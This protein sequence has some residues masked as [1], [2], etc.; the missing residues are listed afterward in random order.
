M[1]V[2]HLS[3]DYP[4]PLAPAKTRAVS[5]L[6]ALVSEIEH[7]VYALNRVGWR[8][9]IHALSFDDACGAGH[10]AVAYGA[11]PKGLLHAVF[12]DRLADWILE[13]LARD[14]FR[15]DLVHAHKLSVEGLAGARVAHA[16]GTP[17]ALS[18]QGNSDTK[19]VGAKRDL[20][21]RYA[22]IW[23]DAAVAFPF[24]PWAARALETM[25]G[26]RDG[27]TLTLPCPGPADGRLPP[28]IVGPIIRTAFHLG[29]ARGKNADGLIRAVGAAAARVPELRLEIA[30]GGDPA[31]FAALSRV[32]ARAA[33]GR[34]RFLGPVPH[35]RVQALFNAS[36]A[37]A[38]V[39]HRESFG[40]VF[41]EALSAGAP[42]LTPRG[43]AIDGYFEEG[44]VVLAADPRDGAE[45][46]DG[47][48]RLALEEAAFKARLAALSESGG[49]DFLTSRAI[50]RQYRSGIA[51]AVSCAGAATG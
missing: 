2:L 43:R 26:R 48:V 38:L 32:A 50:A 46:R 21:D 44:G 35:D 41:A 47:L 10:R 24:A 28:R 31:Q 15:P 18:I 3:A 16:L 49:L 30:G 33:P 42:C 19:I 25:L 45:I 39:S 23:R 8:A 14:G 4:D 7:R 29:G 11:P 13:D 37:F 17:L 27:P 34:V 1:R 22:R 6:L 36:C 5:N 20:R 12:L 9:G 40:M 51:A